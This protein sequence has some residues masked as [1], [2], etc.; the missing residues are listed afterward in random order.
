M[1][2]QQDKFE[3]SMQVILDRGSMCLDTVDEIRLC[4]AAGAICGVRTYQCLQE[5]YTAIHMAGRSGSQVLCPPFQ[6]RLT[7]NDF[8]HE[9]ATFDDDKIL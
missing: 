5:E 1:M 4:T 7:P 3:K 2:A 6:F 9:W 8:I